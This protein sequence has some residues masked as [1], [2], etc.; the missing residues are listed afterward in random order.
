MTS[1]MKMPPAWFYFTVRAF[2]KVLA[3]MVL[4]EEVRG[5]ALVPERG[6]FL[7]VFNHLSMVDAP[8]VLI[9]FPQQMVGM[10]TDKY[11]STPFISQLGK[12]MGIVWVARGEADMGAIKT[13]LTH[14]RA[15]GILALSPEGTRSTEGGLL[16]GKTGAAYLAD[17]TGVPIVPI[18]IAGSENV[19][20]NLRRGRRTPVLVSIGAPFQLPAGGRAKTEKLEEYTDLIMH[21]LAELL[22][23]D[24]RGEY[25]GQG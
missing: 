22:P 7:V 5:Q 17:R 9:H 12:L 3:S 1:R 6:P 11:F 15:G 20:H 8:L 23:P 25:A 14:L 10:M 4:K 19:F 13:S 2:F 24:Y 16:K 21:R 18:A